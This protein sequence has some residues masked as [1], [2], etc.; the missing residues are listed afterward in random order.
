[1]ENIREQY[2]WV[3]KINEFSASATESFFKMHVEVES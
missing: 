1:M 3:D 2:A